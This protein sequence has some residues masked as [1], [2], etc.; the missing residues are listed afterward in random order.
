[1]IN[2]G[3]M[4]SDLVKIYMYRGTVISSALTGNSMQDGRIAPC[5]PE[6]YYYFSNNHPEYTVEPQNNNTVRI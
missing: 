6:Y 4:Q 1:M 3:A 2:V 5:S